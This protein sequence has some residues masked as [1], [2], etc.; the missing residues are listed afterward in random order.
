MCSDA[1]P[2][3]Q[4]VSYL[5]THVH[6]G[7]FSSSLGTTGVHLEA[8]DV[9]PST[10]CVHL[11]IYMYINPCTV[12]YQLSRMK[13][14]FIGSAFVIYLFTSNLRNQQGTSLIETARS[15]R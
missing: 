1:S 8:I 13:F 9:H 15:P 11:G 6:P 14:Y 2:S 4:L 12:C 7:P 10:T 5:I 3:D